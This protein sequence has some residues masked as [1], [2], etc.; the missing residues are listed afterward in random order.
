MCFHFAVAGF[1]GRVSVPE[2]VKA[3]MDKKLMLDEF[4]TH[5][6]TLDEINDAFD[7]MR[8]GK[9]YIQMWIIFLTQS[10]NL[11]I[12]FFILFFCSIRTVMNISTE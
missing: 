8:E 4:I 12:P 3:Y 9:R 10:A 2:M 5:T 6:M 11:L 1:K 7:L